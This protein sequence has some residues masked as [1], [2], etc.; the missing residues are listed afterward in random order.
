MWLHKICHS[1]EL[2][3]RFHLFPPV[4]IEYLIRNQL[5]RLY[6]YFKHF[7]IDLVLVFDGARNP[8]KKETDN[9]RSQASEKAN[10]KFR[11]IFE[12]KDNANIS[13]IKSLMKKSIY[14]IEDIIYHT[15]V[16]ARENQIKCIGAP[17]EADHQ[18]V[19]LEMVGATDGTIADDS[20]ISALGSKLLVTMCHP[21]DLKS[22]TV[23]PCRII[24]REK[25]DLKKKSYE[26]ASSVSTCLK[27]KGANSN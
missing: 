11:T 2:A 8:R 25:I 1:D 7:E 10:T 5:K 23:G 17:F 16:F 9:S 4:S 21:L 22:N 26:L 15:V 13:N 24:N 14:V 18:L 3:E 6:L 20:D 27:K 19:Y 12:T